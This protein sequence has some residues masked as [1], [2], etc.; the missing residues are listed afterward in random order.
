[1]YQLPKPR[2]YTWH[3]VQECHEGSNTPRDPPLAPRADPDVVTQHS[4]H[5]ELCQI[6]SAV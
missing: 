1:M 4:V 5:T 3:A 2:G 6:E